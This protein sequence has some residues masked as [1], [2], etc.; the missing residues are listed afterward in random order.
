[1]SPKSSSRHSVI[2]NL[3]LS[4]SSFDAPGKNPSPLTPGAP[5]SGG[6]SPLT[7][8]S[9]R[10]TP[11]SP[12]AKSTIRPVTQWA[13][14]PD[15]QFLRAGS[16]NPTGEPGTPSL[17]AIPQYPPSPRESPKHNRDPSRSFFANLKATRS[18]HKI[19][20]SDGSVNSDNSKSRGSSRDRTIYGTRHHGSSPDLLS[21]VEGTGEGKGGEGSE[22]PLGQGGLHP[23]KVPTEPENGHVVVSKKSKPRF[24]NLLSRSRSIRH[25]DG[26]SS[27]ATPVRRPST[28]LARLEERS[29][30][31]LEEPKTAPL[32]HERIG[33]DGTPA[34]RNRSTDR[35]GEN[36]SAAGKKGGAAMVTSASFSQVSG[37]SVALFSNIKQS[38]TSTADR[39]G[40][41]G[42]G[43]FGKITRSGSTNERELL[44]DDSY[45]CSVINLPLIE[46]TRRTRIAKRLEDCKDKTEFWMPALP[47]RCIDYLNFKG[48]EEEGLYR[49]PGSGREVKHWQRRFDSELDINLFDEPELYDINIIGSMFKAWLRELPDELFPKSTQAMIAEKCEGAT[50]APQMLKDELSKLPPYNYYLLF[51]ITCHLNLLHSYVDQNKMDYRN[52]CI[53]F[54]PCMKIDGFCFQFLV[55]DWKNCWQGCWTE[56]EWLQNEK[57]AAVKAAKEKENP[58]PASSQGST[59][60]ER[61]IS[62]SGSSQHGQ[63]E[64]STHSSSPRGRKAPPKRLDNTHMRSASQLPELGPPLSPIHI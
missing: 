47:Y 60:D 48:C 30:R 18:S 56:K 13:S 50:T 42:K 31:E 52:L 11:S 5:S 22:D 9:P 46:Q 10:S 59:N 45:T 29:Q 57:E 24:A 4:S 28:G 53:C 12:F 23:K 33:K 44:N 17:T 54:Q 21:S 8:R 32:R 43:F 2:P 3:D 6:L 36:G 7:P 27:R 16:P 61:A 41:V 55:C 63:E 49:V 51:A 19:H 34:V 38:S 64:S 39:I 14:K 40:R 58:V 25:D 37:A 35:L 20:T 15:D 1:M 26:T 62:S